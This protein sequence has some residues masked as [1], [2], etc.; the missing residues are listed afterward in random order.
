VDILERCYTG[1]EVRDETLW[2]D[3]LLPDELAGLRFNVL[4]RGCEIAVDVEGR[5]LRLEAAD[6]R[7]N[8]VTVMVSGTPVVLHPGRVT[9]IDLEK[10]E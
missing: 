10:T 8:S 7:A 3:P 5:R 4:F 9:E 2:F 6:G 1:M